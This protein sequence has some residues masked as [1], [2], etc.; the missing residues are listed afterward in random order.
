MLGKI[1]VQFKQMIISVKKKI[2][3]DLCNKHEWHEGKSFVI[4]LFPKSRFS[5]YV[6]TRGSEFLKIIVV[7][8]MMNSRKK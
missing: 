1:T 4:V 3:D 6:M 5:E 8:E 2:H 7:L